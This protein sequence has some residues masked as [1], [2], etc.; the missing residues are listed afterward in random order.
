MQLVAPNVS[1]AESVLN[2][3]AMVMCWVKFRKNLSLVL[4]VILGEVLLQASVASASSA[5]ARVKGRGKIF[6]YKQGG[7][8]GVVIFWPPVFCLC[9]GARCLLIF[10]FKKATKKVAVNS[11]PKK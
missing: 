3:E 5:T 2:V 8:R 9:V 1:V 7:W 10:F 4:L 11:F 6:N